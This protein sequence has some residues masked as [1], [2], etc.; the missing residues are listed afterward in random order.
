MK[1]HKWHYFNEEDKLCIFINPVLQKQE[2]YTLCGRHPY[3]VKRHT[4]DKS[5]V[6]CL[7]CLTVLNTMTEVKQG[8]V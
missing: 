4:E 5:Q 1:Q 3:N 2:F 6:D 8:N 7:Q